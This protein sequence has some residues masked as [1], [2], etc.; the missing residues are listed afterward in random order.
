MNVLTWN[1][2][3]AS[4]RLLKPVSGRRKYKVTLWAQVE[5]KDGEERKSTSLTFTGLLA[6]IATTASGELC[7][8]I[9]GEVVIDAGYTV[10][11]LR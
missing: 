4:A 11:L 5:R 8:L 1:I 3:D 10:A 7:E 9:A 6:E 2:R